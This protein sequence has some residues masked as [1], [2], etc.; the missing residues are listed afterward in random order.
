MSVSVTLKLR[1]LAMEKIAME[2][3]GK[4]PNIDSIECIFPNTTEPELKGFYVLKVEPLVLKQ[5]LDLLKQ[6][7]DVEYVYES[8]ER[9]LRR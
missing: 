9:K 5:T 6:D 3:I 1:K 2:R 8:P 7:P 4:I